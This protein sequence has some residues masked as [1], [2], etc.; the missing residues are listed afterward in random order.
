MQVRKCFVIAITAGTALSATAFGQLADSVIT[1]AEAITPNMIQGGDYLRTANPYAS[2]AD[3]EV[4]QIGVPSETGGVFAGSGTN[5][6]DDAT[7]G[8]P[9]TS[10]AN[11][12]VLNGMSIG[13]I[14]PAVFPDPNGDNLYTRVTFYPNHDTLIADPATP[15]SGTP[16]VVANLNWG[17]GWTTGATPGSVRYYAA[18]ITFNGT[19]ATL[20]NADVFAGGPTDRT[21]GV[22]IEPYLDAALT[23]RAENWQVVR[24]AGMVGAKIGSTDSWGWFSTAANVASGELNQNSRSGGGAF[25]TSVVPNVNSGNCRASYMG[26]QGTGFTVAPPAFTDLGTLAD[27]VTTSSAQTGDVKWYKFTISAAATDNTNTFIDFDNEGAT[28]DYSLALY[29]GNEAAAGFG[30]VIDFDTDTGSGTNAMLSYGMGRR[31]AVG[32]G[33]QYD[34]RNT[35][36]TA[37]LAAGTYY[38]AIAPAG[39]SFAGGFNVTPATL[40]APATSSVNIRT[41]VNGAPLAPSVQPPIAVADD[42]SGSDLLSPG[43]QFAAAALNEGEVR[44]I[45][46]KL[47]QPADDTNTVTLDWTGTDVAG[48]A[49]A[50]IFDSSGNLVNQVI[51]AGTG[52]PPQTVFNS[53]NPLP[54]GTLYMAQAY[55][56]IQIQPN[57]PATNGRW[58]VRATTPNNGFAFGGGLFVSYTECAPACPGNACG[59]QDYNGDGDFGTD[60]DIE[61]FFACL[62]GN[63][64]ATCF[65][66]GSD[67]NGDGDFGTDQ[68]IEAFFRVLGGG[69]C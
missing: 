9:Y 30:T 61:A 33:R 68:D 45:A 43:I 65:C 49:S 64:C 25:A 15:Y 42:F 35:D 20:T 52:T 22:K 57:S 38:I 27:G 31:A 6:Y 13:F 19:I 44:W 10:N 7:F 36:G 55:S 63:C 56:G 41:N 16:T 23:I 12:L 21:A 17:A 14:L 40:P 48:G 26:F 62:G 34:G 2:R 5:V 4:Y 46:F 28:G 51:Y 39:S 29:N 58:H 53:S 59:N 66:Q 47:C 50:S 37:G 24:R 8:G 3:L 1:N 69:N 11:P 18:S 54:A 32:D 60:Q 67:F